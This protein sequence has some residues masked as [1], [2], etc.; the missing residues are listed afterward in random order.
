MDNMGHLL[1]RHE[2]RVAVCGVQNS[3]KTV[4][5]TS[6][7]DHLLHHDPARNVADDRRFDLGDF[8][9][10]DDADV[11][12][13]HAPGD[14]VANFEFR[15]FRKSF[16]ENRWPEKTAM[17][18]ELV[19]DFTLEN[20]RGTSLIP[21]GRLS[22]R[23]DVRLRILDVPGER[24]ADFLMAGH[25]FA[26]WSD[27]LLG[28]GKQGRRHLDAYRDGAEN[29]IGGSADDKAAEDVLLSEYRKALDAAK[30]V[31][32]RFV[33]PSVYRVPLDGSPD[34]PR[35]LGLA[36]REFAPVPASLRKRF[37]ELAKRF[38]RNYAAYRDSIV[39]PIVDWMKTA[40][41]ALFLLDVFSCLNGGALAYNG[42]L[43]E[44]N[45]ALDVFASKGALDD[46]RESLGYLFTRFQLPMDPANVRIVVTKMDLA[47]PAGREN[48]MALARQM[49]GKKAQTVT[50]FP[51]PGAAFLPCASVVTDEEKAGGSE[52]K[53]KAHPGIPRREDSVLQRPGDGIPWSIPEN[54]D[55]WKFRFPLTDRNPAWFNLREDLPPKHSGL[56]AV[57]RFILGI[58]APGRKNRGETGKRKEPGR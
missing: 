18:A 56:D 10:G 5:I 1:S 26:D 27:A 7:A 19:L 13:V 50:G 55:D 53:K 8:V 15:K 39:D 34:S 58:P 46:V 36:N 32:D 41:K 6:L 49:F 42:A 17:T 33:T 37:P 9:V 48:L 12:D 28:N 54:L 14:S 38:A 51:A 23:R 2:I 11:K 35:F 24:L 25:D 22:R 40:D 44:T 43:A 52:T 47:D 16:A 30:G 57:A 4:F 31:Y 45:A 29:A 3:G 20:V 21:V